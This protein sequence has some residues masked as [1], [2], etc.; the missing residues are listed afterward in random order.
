MKH[1]YAL[2]FILTSLFCFGQEWEPIATLPDNFNTDHS[3]AFSID[4]VG[5]IVA[6]NTPTGFSSSFYSYNPSTDEWTRKEDFPGAARGFAIGDVWNGKAYFGFGRSTSGNRDDFWEYDPATDEWT[7]LA[8]C[9][10]DARTHP[11]M[12]A[13]NGEIYVGLGGTNNGDSNDWWVYDIESNTWEERTRFPASERHHPFQFTDGEYVYVGFGHGGPNIYNEFYRYNTLDDTWIE[14]QTLPAE[15]RVAGTQLSYKG[16]GLILSGDGDNH[17]VMPTGEFWMYEPLLDQWTALPPHPGSS[18]WAPA[19]FILDDEVYFLNGERNG[20]YYRDNFKFNL[21]YLT[22]PLLS[23]ST[24][25]ELSDLA[26]S[27]DECNAS[28]VQKITVGSRIAFDE[29]VIVSLTVDPS[30]TAVEGD[31][32]MLELAETTLAAGEDNVD[33]DLTILD[34]AVVNGDK[35]LRLNLVTDAETIT[36]NLEINLLENDIEFGTESLVRELEIGNGQLGS[37]APFARYYENARSQMLYR[38]DMLIG[39]GLGAG[40]ISKIAFEVTSTAEQTFLGFTI[41]IAHTD[42]QQFNGNYTTSLDFEQVF[43]GTYNSKNGLND[44]EFDTPFVYDGESN[45]VIQICFDNGDWTTDDITAAT[46]VG[47]N[48]TIVVQADGVNGCPN[49]GE[50]TSTTEL[51]NLI[52]YKEGFFPVYVDVNQK[53]QSEILE[54]E[55]IY[56]STNDSIY[57]VIEHVSGEESS[58]FSSNLMSNTNDIKQ[59]EDFDWIDRVYQIENE[60][61]VPSDYEVTVFMP[62]IG[63]LDF[64]SENLVGLY[65]SEEMIDGEDPQWEALD[66]VSTEINPDFVAVKFE[67]QGNGNYTVGGEGIMTSTNE[68]PLD[69]EYD[70]ITIYDAMGRIIS[71]NSNEVN[72]SELP[73][74]LYFKSYINEGKVIKTVKV[75]P[76]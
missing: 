27:D 38:S 75:I 12:V 21:R 60:G 74:G 64:T 15:G 1:L 50:V 2:T 58:C 56:F 46:D 13:L 17:G 30:S 31:D 37:I 41:N 28:Q 25:G 26:F 39:A 10:C 33:F 72:L 32:F 11:A 66:I 67:F 8:T 29:D 18:R 48:S 53:F 43:S 5:Y 45:I 73:M 7:Q 47:Y 35:V 40:E 57:A 9:D 49:T 19:S 65:T 16:L 3:F 51:P 23:V 70:M 44:I 42:L 71:T 36:E 68:I 62:N 34:D 76:N 54:N 61:G 63:D 14:V 59:A 20:F 24:D 22:E 4:G 55:T 52:I 6:G 69:I